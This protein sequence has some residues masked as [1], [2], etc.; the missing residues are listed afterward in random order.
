MTTHLAD[1]DWAWA[2]DTGGNLTAAQRRRLL[3]S[4]PRTVAGFVPGRVRLALGRRGIGRVE[5][6]GLRLPDTPLAKAAEEHARETLSDAL[7]AHS[8]RTYFFARA[9]ADLDR[10]T[11][12]D[13]IA[14]VSSLLH[15]IALE[16]PT[17]GRCFAVVG[18][19]SAVA[20]AH[21]HGAAPDRAE[22][23]GAAIA[24]HLTPGIAAN[25]ADPGGFVSAGASVD[26]LGDRL[27]DL[28]P[29]WTADLL[30]RHPRHHLTRV[31][32]AAFGAE[33]AAVPHGRVAWLSGTGFL[34]LI[35]LAPFAE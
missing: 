4:L 35:R 12:D 9:L 8:F 23:I 20:F 28:D 33:A 7:L 6:D 13:E 22:T 26:V 16:T 10:A 29:T 34:Q 30:A 25:L 2:T 17:P 14:Y 18:A 3:L 5:F 24:A 32:T 27:A 21:R 19:E 11:Y 15:D 31:L 1:L